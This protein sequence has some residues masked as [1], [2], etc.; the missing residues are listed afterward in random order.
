MICPLR[1][2]FSKY[3]KIDPE[4]ERVIFGHDFVVLIP[5]AKP[6]HHPTSKFPSAPKAG[7]ANPP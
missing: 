5:D 2:E 1:Q 3:G 6:S 7:A 4:P